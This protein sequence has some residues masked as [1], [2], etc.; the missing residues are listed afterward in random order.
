MVKWTVRS[1]RA[2]YLALQRTSCVTSGELLHVS[3]PFPVLSLFRLCSLGARLPSMMQR[4]AEMP[5]VDPAL[6]GTWLCQ[7]ESAAEPSSSGS[8]PGLAV[9]HADVAILF[10]RLI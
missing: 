4:P 9:G 7:C 8:W 3:L 2:Q 10:F 5:K 6:R 1:S